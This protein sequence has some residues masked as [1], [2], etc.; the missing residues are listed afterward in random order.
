MRK[1]IPSK[2]LS[3]DYPGQEAMRAIIEEMCDA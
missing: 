2:S 1:D 3:P